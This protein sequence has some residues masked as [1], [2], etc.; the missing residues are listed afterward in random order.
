MRK[1]TYLIA[2]LILALCL[3][4]CQTTTRVYLSSWDT[5]QGD[6]L[7]KYSSISKLKA[8]QGPA[9][10]Y[11][12]CYYGDISDDDMDALKSDLKSFLSGDEFLAEYVAY[13]NE[14]AEKNTSNFGLMKFMPDIVISLY[15]N[16]VTETAWAWASEARYYTQPYRSDRMMEV[17]N[18]QT[19]DDWDYSE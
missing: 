14:K 8:E 2:G 6:M 3:A 7:K 5:F 12:D 17:D 1:R 18:Y 9:S 4:G 19:W 13:A 16:G 10:L 15:P 11:I